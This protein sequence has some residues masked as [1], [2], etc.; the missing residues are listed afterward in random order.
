MKEMLGT[1]NQPCAPVSSPCPGDLATFEGL[2]GDRQQRDRR[3]GEEAWLFRSDM[4]TGIGA[5]R[6]GRWLFYLAR[7][8]RFGVVHALRIIA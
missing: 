4:S 5:D 6:L 1:A 2:A 3:S 8:D 7:L